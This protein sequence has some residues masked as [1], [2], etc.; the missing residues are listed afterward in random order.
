MKRFLILILGFYSLSISA[1]VLPEQKEKNIE[2]MKLYNQA[3]HCGELDLPENKERVFL[4]QDLSHKESIRRWYGVLSLVNA[5][6]VKGENGKRF[7]FSEV[8]Q[9]NDDF[10]VV[11]GDLIRDLN[12]L[13]VDLIQPEKIVSIHMYQPFIITIVVENEKKEQFEYKILLKDDG[14]HHDAHRLAKVIVNYQPVQ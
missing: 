9:T 4:I 1:E 10:R 13:K 5:H 6:C 2:V 3:V 7:L 8:Y 12:E 14:Y 11:K